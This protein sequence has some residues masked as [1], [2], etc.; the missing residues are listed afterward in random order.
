MMKNIKKKNLVEF[1]PKTKKEIA[2]KSFSPE[3]DEEEETTKGCEY[4][5]EKIK[6]L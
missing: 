5:V 1:N 6:L 3:P 2:F 4:K